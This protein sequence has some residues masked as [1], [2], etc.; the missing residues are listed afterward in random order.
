MSAKSPVSFDVGGGDPLVAE[1]WASLDTDAAEALKEKEFQERLDQATMYR[2]AYTTEAGRFVLQEMINAYLVTR[3]VDP[4]QQNARADGIRQ[5]GQDVV[6]RI[7]QMIEFANTGGG[8]P[9]NPQE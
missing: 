9:P 5:G 1:G 8:R 2:L 3:I 4:A 7:L 6:I